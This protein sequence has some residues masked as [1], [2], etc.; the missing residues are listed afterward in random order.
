MDRRHLDASSLKP[1]QL[2]LEPSRKTRS[3]I[4]KELALVEIATC[5]ALVALTSTR[6]SRFPM[7]SSTI[8]AVGVRAVKNV[9]AS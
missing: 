9:A 5:R 3:T 6:M 8:R 1:L 4:A 2:S 7:S